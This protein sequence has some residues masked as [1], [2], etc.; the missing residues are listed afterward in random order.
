MKR[1]F[2][3]VVEILEARLMPTAIGGGGGGGSS[4]GGGSTGGGSGAAVSPDFGLPW[5]SH[6]LTL[7]FV[8]DGTLVGGLPSQLFR[9]LNAEMPTAIW[10]G[11]ILRAFQTWAASA[12]LNIGVVPDD[13]A[14]LGAPGPLQGDPNFGDIRIAAVPGGTSLAAGIPLTPAAGTWSGDVIFNSAAPFGVGNSASAYDLF[15]VAVHEAGH[16]L[17]LADDLDPSSVMFSYY[18]YRTGLSNADIQSIQALYGARPADPFGNSTMRTATPF[19]PAAL[20]QY[21]DQFTDPTQAAGNL[22][23]LAINGDL[24]ATS[25]VD[26]FSCQ[27]VPGRSG[28]TVELHTAGISALEGE[29]TVLDSSGQVVASAAAT[30]PLD[31]DLSLHIDGGH[32]SQVYYIEVRGA[33][34]DVFS[35]GS[36][37]L[38]MVPDSPVPLIPFKLVDLFSRFL[39]P[40]DNHSLGTATSVAADG[41]TTFSAHG[42]IG[43]SGEVDYYRLVAPPPDI[44]GMPES[45]TVMAWGQAGSSLAPSVNV[46]DAQGN[47]I[48]AAA[49]ASGN[50]SDVVT[51]PNAQPGAVYYVSV[52]APA[53]TTGAHSLGVSFSTVPDSTQVFTSGQLIAG[54]GQQGFRSI[55]VQQNML[56]HFDFSAQTPGA[57]VQTAVEITLFNMQGQVLGDWTVTNG[58]QLSVN[59]YLPA[60]SYTFRFVGGTQDGS[61]L[62][63]TTYSISGYPVND[64]IGPPLVPPTE[65]PPSPPLPFQWL[66]AALY[67]VLALV[68]PYG[69][70]LPQQAY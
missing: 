62:P 13:G 37:Q 9:S 43:S 57:T 6:Q 61:P 2:R 63:A 14:P 36:Y 23:P 47:L 46:Y 54:V 40:P 52:Q 39:P 27:T 22:P 56:F 17:G 38:Q 20:T 64:P 68:D 5:P 60:G 12:N 50:G 51:V 33:T 26:Y 28:F 34:G 25:D 48:N 49:V 1:T 21:I 65:T 69:H 59:L 42:Q 30:D 18:S 3:P 41:P 31:G 8:P 7:S 66:Q 55:V 16:A 67:Q 35:I 53:G 45:M 19:A 11:Q 70:P 29:V 24:V 44:A 10:E 58:Q 4:G 32:R 15:S